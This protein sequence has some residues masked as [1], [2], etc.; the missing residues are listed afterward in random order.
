[1]SLALSAGPRSDRAWAQT[2]H[3]EWTKL[4]TLAGTWWL[5]AGAVALTVAVSAAAVAAAAVAPGLDPAKLSLTGIQAGQAVV[6]VLAVLVI[7]D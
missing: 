7:S 3:A 2:L 1:M 6:A 5:L 4:R